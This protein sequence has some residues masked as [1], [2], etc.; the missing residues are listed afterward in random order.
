M[1]IFIFIENSTRK[2]CEIYC[3]LMQHGLGPR[4]SKAATVLV[5]A[6][7]PQSSRQESYYQQLSVDGRS[8][9]ACY[10]ALG[11]RSQNAQQQP[12]A[13]RLEQ[14]LPSQQDKQSY[15]VLLSYQQQQQEEV[16][17]PSVLLV[18]SRKVL[19]FLLL[20]Q[21]T[22]IYIVAPANVGKNIFSISSSSLYFH[23]NVF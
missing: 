19:L 23:Q 7:G 8:S 4:T 13:S 2:T 3:I 22:S 17:S 9:A 12:W 10:S 18:H 21:A 14:S 16:G 1:C 15:D 20:Y 5:V 6:V 11:P